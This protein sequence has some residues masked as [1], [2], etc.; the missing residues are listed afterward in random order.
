[1]RM[2]LHVCCGPCSVFPLKHLQE[3]YSQY[4]VTGYFYNPN[5]HPYKE[6]VRRL[7]TLKAFAQKI[8][9]NNLI[10][11]ERYL[12]D[13]FLR[14]AL[15]APCGRCRNC[16]D[17]RMKQTARYAKE[18]GF[19]CFSTTLLV[20]PYQQ[21]DL[22]KEAAEEAAKAVGINFCYIDFRPGWQAGVTR[23]RELE[24]YRQPY[25]GCIFSEKDRYYKPRK[26]QS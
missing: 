5:I 25:C 15:A 6:F 3:E 22:I 18:N 14:Q 4:E 20:S 11:D 9:L 21:H 8:G 24:M 17:M 2:L 19:D 12:L 23:S 16:Y 13:E 1:M 10:I 7:D 26:G